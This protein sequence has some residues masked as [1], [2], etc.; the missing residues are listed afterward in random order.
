MDNFLNELVKEIVGAA[1]GGDDF[2]LTA[3]GNAGVC[4]GV[5]SMGIGVKSE[6]VEDARASFAGLGIGI[7][8]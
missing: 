2:E 7:G 8:R 3:P 6:F 4:N 5:K 1:M